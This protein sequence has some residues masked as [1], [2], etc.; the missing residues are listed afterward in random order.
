M[1]ADNLF[2]DPQTGKVYRRTDAGYVEVNP[3]AAETGPAEAALIGAGAMA[4]DVMRGAQMRLGQVT[5]NARTYWPAALAGEDDA[6][7][8]A[9]L[10]QEQPAAFVAGQIAPAL[11]LPIGA[12]MG[13]GRGALTGAGLGALTPEG[14]PMSSIY[15]GAALGAVGGVPG[16][17]RAWREG[18]RPQT[19]AERVAGLISARAQGMVD[20]A[21]DAAALGTRPAANRG[22]ASLD[23]MGQA[24]AGHD[25]RARMA[26]VEPGVARDAELAARGYDPAALA[27][28]D[29]A[30]L[31]GQAAQR[32][33]SGVQQWA[34]ETADRLGF[35]L[36]AGQRAQNPE[37]L[38]AETSFRRTPVF[39]SG[40]S[41]L[42][43]ANRGTMNKIIS[44][45]LEAPESGS[46]DNAT[47][48]A[49]HEFVSQAFNKAAE[50][51]RARGGVPAG[52]L[53]AQLQGIIDKWA[54]RD[55]KLPGTAWLDAS[56]SKAKGGSAT[57]DPD[58]LLAMRQSLNTRIRS[59]MRT[60]ESVPVAG[61]EEQIAAIDAAMSAAARSQSE[62]L[63]RAREVYRL[64]L[65]LEKRGVVANEGNV[66]YQS[67]YN[68]LRFGS[69]KGEMMGRKDVSGGMRDLV[70]AMRA[71]QTVLRDMVPNSGTPTGLSMQQFM[72]APL[73]TSAQALGG[74]ILSQIY[75]S[76][77]MGG[78]AARLRAATDARQAQQV[79]GLW[80]SMW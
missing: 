25:L 35:K 78:A 61:L 2:Q 13:I 33:L 21:G 53:Q 58:G 16:S 70:D 80:G 14:D 64:L 12:G 20:E 75:T 65:A 19:R 7:A 76:P 11:A 18:A 51:A 31:G 67:L 52:G 57:I 36:T 29:P 54:A 60:G 41:Q 56:M 77:R 23:E 42:D 6:G 62:A 22:L 28:V 38:M 30:L 3:A 59:A 69:Y 45:A 8:R 66:N 47:L 68:N 24:Q 15:L 5:G 17:V 63:P 72:A 44:R 74:R 46:I 34:L 73:R 39:S 32:Q 49:G 10:M 55:V 26:G 40:F 37:W 9:D 71:W 43:D 1:M 48:N 50:A 27:G 79:S 4:T